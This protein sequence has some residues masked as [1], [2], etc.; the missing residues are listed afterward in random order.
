MK[1]SRWRLTSAHVIAL[2]ALFVALGGT[3]YAAGGFSGRDIRRGSLPGNRIAND[4]VTGAQ[5][6]ES[7]LGTVPSATRAAAATRSD[8]ATKADFATKAAEVEKA[9]LAE[10]ATKLNGIAAGEYQ[11]F[12][13]PG[14]I[15]GFVHYLENG[16]T[17]APGIIDEFSC[18][19]AKVTV[20]QEKEANG[21]PVVG[22]FIVDFGQLTRPIGGV[23]SVSNPNVSANVTHLSEGRFRV[24][25][26]VTFNAEVNDQ[27]QVSLIVF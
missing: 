14:A 3:V 11:R 22:S 7:S 2:I 17:T 25:T 26:F 9:T 5:V 4:S 8:V 23:A 19:G 21:N 27:S 24:R 18:S 15:R 16:P 10:S 20:E 6:E 12:C 1:F 13:Q